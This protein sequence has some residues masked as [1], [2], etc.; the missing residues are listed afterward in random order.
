VG[1]AGGAATRPALT[2]P[3]QNGGWKTFTNPTFK[4]QGQCVKHLIHSRNAAHKQRTASSITHE[5][6]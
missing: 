4:N 6:T 3:C 1:R 5:E 2:A